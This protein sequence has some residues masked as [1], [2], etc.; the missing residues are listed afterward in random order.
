MTEETKCCVD[1]VLVH[2][3]QQM[4]FTEVDLFPAFVDF[5]R[6]LLFRADHFSLS[7]ISGGPIFPGLFSV[8]IFTEYQARAVKKRINWQFVMYSVPNNQIGDGR[9]SDQARR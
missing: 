6:P 2:I 3:L 7:L 1:C 5:F 4:R 8:G 9:P